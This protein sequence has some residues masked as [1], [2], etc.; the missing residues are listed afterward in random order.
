MDDWN[1]NAKHYIVVAI[2]AGLAGGFFITSLHQ[3]S[4]TTPGGLSKIAANL[5]LSGASAA[6]ANVTYY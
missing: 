6:G 4:S 2:I 3:P 5:W 1:M